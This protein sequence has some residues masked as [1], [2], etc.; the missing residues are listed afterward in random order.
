VQSIKTPLEALLLTS[1]IL[2][3]DPTISRVLSNVNNRWDSLTV[4]S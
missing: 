3:I 2:A 4:K 1:L